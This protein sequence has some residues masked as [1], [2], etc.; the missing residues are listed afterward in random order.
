MSGPAGVRVH[1]AGA[2]ALALAR[3]FGSEAAKL[4]RQVEVC[5]GY[6]PVRDHRPHAVVISAW[7]VPAPVPVLTASLR[8]VGT[9]ARPVVFAPPRL[10]VGG[11]IA[12]TV[13]GSCHSWPLEEMGRPALS[14]GPSQPAGEGGYLHSHLELA[15]ALLLDALDGVG[16]TGPTTE[17]GAELVGGT[18]GTR[19]QTCR[20][21]PRER[22][23]DG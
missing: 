19:Q 23:E 8:A 11:W 5:P 18:L 16:P 6:E 13:C 1:A 7:P 2:A 15:L 4:G 22:A 20:C 21:R 9:L 17:R 3:A 14:G 12:P 10:W